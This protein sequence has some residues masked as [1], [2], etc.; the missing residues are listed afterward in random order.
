M[1]VV[2]DNSPVK[3]LSPDKSD[4]YEE[5]SGLKTFRKIWWVYPVNSY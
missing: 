3:A 4:F 1:L 2:H 5:D